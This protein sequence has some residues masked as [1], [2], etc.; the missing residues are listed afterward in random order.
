MNTFS[1]PN[2]DL[3]FKSVKSVLDKKFDSVKKRV[4]EKYLNLAK[5]ELSAEIIEFAT[6]ITL[7]FE[8]Y[9]THGTKDHQININLN[10]PDKR[11]SIKKI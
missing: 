11:P 1:I 4:I 2:N 7:E 3:F 9:L 10:I 8:E 5:E 6:E